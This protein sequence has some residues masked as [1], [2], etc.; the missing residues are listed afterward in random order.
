MAV[1]I[2][3][4]CNSLFV[5]RAVHFDLTEWVDTCNCLSVLT[6]TNNMINCLYRHEGA[7]GIRPRLLRLVGFRIPLEAIVVRVVGSHGVIHLL[8]AI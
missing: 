8:T 3:I 4:L 1:Q 6:T 5:V 2:S 7:T